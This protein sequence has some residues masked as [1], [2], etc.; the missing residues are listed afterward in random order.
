MV[1][2]TYAHGYAP[3]S[4]EMSNLDAILGRFTKRGDWS[5]FQKRNGIVGYAVTQEITHNSTGWNAHIHL[6]LTLSSAHTTAGAQ[7]LQDAITQRWCSAAAWTGHEAVERLQA[8]SW[9]RPGFD[10]ADMAEYVTKQNLLHRAPESARGRYP[11]DLLIGAAAGD[12]D[13]LDRYR[14]Y[15]DAVKGRAPTRAHGRLSPYRV[16]DFDELLRAGAA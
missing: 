15:L 9:M 11:A 1:T 3:L 5:R 6:V 4:N 13:D 12:A 14:E 2:L 16:L 10:A 7:R 8:Y